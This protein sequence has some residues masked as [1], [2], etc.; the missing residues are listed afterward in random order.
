MLIDPKTL[1]VGERLELSRRRAGLSQRGAAALLG[2]P[3]KR[4][5]RAEHGENDEAPAPMIRTLTVGEQCRIMRKREGFTPP[6]LEETS[7]FKAKWIYRVEK[8]QTRS[9]RP[10]VNFWLRYLAEKGAR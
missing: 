3:F 7:G 1:T 8:D 5:L 10:L 6:D 4:Y 9:A 2:W